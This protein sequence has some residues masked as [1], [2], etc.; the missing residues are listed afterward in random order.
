MRQLSYADA[1][2]EWVLRRRALDLRAHLSLTEHEAPLP[3][4]A[5]Q[6]VDWI[7]LHQSRPASRRTIRIGT[8]GSALALAQAYHVQ[9][10]LAEITRGECEISVVPIR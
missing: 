6:L 1:S 10:L 7:L 5:H 4:S 8:R 3:N 9:G 2:R